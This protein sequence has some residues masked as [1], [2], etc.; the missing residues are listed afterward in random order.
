MH[1]FG[2]KHNLPYSIS[3]VNSA[4]MSGIVKAQYLLKQISRDFLVF[5]LYCYFPSVS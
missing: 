3:T 2:N 5:V 4:F 1:S